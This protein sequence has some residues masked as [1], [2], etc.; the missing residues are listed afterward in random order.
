MCPQH[1]ALPAGRSSVLWLGFAVGLDSTMGSTPQASA[2]QGCPP[3]PPAKPSA[4]MAA[5][6]SLY[7]VPSHT[8]A[9]NSLK[10]SLCTL[11]HLLLG[12]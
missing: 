11:C 1:R 10:V 5:A 7:S 3:V 8:Y 9:L 6:M 12:T 2:A 4:P